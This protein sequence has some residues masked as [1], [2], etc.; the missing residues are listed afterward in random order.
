M[1]LHPIHSRFT[2]IAGCLNELF[3]NTGYA[4]DIQGPGLTGRNVSW[5]T[6]FVIGKTD[7]I[8]R[9]FIS[10]A[11][12]RAFVGLQTLMGDTP[13]MP[14]LSKNPT[15]HVMYGRCHLSPA[16]YLFSCVDT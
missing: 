1:N 6:I 13:H 15:A 10:G 11:L 5:I 12:R 8:L 7:G 2:G 14:N 3:P 4:I 9:L 16:L